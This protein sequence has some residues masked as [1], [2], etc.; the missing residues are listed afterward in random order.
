[1][2]SPDD[3]KTT[4]QLLSYYDDAILDLASIK[5][6]SGDAPA[7]RLRLYKARAALAARIDQVVPHG[8]QNY[9]LR[10]EGLP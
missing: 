10:T 5:R 6:S 3:G 8:H 7:A 4:E 1:M 9:Q 2:P